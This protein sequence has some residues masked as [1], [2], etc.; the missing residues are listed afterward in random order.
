MSI[1]QLIKPE[2]IKIDDHFWNTF[3]HSETEVSA[4]WI[5][6]FLRSR[7]AVEDKG[8]EAFPLK[9][10]TSFYQCLRNQP[11]EWFNFNRLNSMYVF[12]N[13]DGMVEVTDK[14]VSSIASNSNLLS[15]EPLECPQKYKDVYTSV[16]K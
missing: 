4:R 12:P 13:E 10:L 11:R 6:M 3:D 5:V 8:W 9:D 15:A 1:K 2:N 16:C 14:F 7:H